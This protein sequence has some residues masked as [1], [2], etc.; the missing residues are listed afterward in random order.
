[1]IEV[2]RPLFKRGWRI[3]R[4]DSV[5]IRV[6]DACLARDVNSTVC[7]IW[8]SDFEVW[9]NSFHQVRLS[10]SYIIFPGVSFCPR[11]VFALA[12][13]FYSKRSPLQSAFTGARI[14]N[15]TLHC[16]LAATAVTHVEWIK[17]KHNVLSSNWT[18]HSASLDYRFL[19]S[20]AVN[21]LT[22]EHPHP[23]CVQC[24]VS[25]SFVF[26][27]SAS[28]GAFICGHQHA[29]FSSKDIFNSSWFD[30]CWPVAQRIGWIDFCVM[31]ET[32]FCIW[33]NRFNMTE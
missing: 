18:H 14:V 27:I 5:W 21:T 19:L 1:M 3:I 30:L 4:Q 6:D 29:I 13:G 2:F 11:R 31:G 25:N 26:S 9:I 24:G 16:T 28:K 33:R 23:H 15:I 8:V 22:S 17:L 12:S 7:K 20:D 10:I 32:E